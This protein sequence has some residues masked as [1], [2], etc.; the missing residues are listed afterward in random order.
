MTIDEIAT[1]N[2]HSI[3]GRLENDPPMTSETDTLLR[4]YYRF[5]AGECKK[6]TDGRDFP[7]T[8]YDGEVRSN[9][10]LRNKF[11][12]VM[13]VGVRMMKAR[14]REDTSQIGT[15][16]WANSSVRDLGA[17]FSEYRQMIDEAYK[18]LKGRGLSFNVS[19]FV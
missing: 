10:E 3:E 1:N 16:F 19:D 9:E 12:R 4:D 8:F 17:S 6:I 18:N 15:H 2:V 7:F 13:K 11:G 5:L 14:G